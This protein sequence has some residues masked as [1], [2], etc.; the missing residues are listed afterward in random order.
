VSSLARVLE[1]L[2][3]LVGQQTA[4]GSTATQDP[5]S[6]ERLHDLVLPPPVSP[7]PATSGWLLLAFAL[8]VATVG[9]LRLLALRR[10]ARAYRVE[11]LAELEQLAAETVAPVGDARAAALA[12]LPDLVKRTA[13]AAWPRE[14]VASLTGAPWLTFL[15]ETSGD[16]RW[17]SPTGEALVA[18]AYDPRAPAE[19]DEATTAELLQL[20]RDWIRRHVAPRSGEETAAC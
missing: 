7:W 6:L 20:S 18:L 12:R 3:V 13:L 9:L 8:A 16:E 10:R 19:L 11:A 4:D 1:N 17:R 2:A 5:A 15:A 14:R